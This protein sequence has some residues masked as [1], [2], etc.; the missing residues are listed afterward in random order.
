MISENRIKAIVEQAKNEGVVGDIKSVLQHAMTAGDLIKV[1]QQFHSDTPVEL[2]IPVEIDK[3]T[4]EMFS[5]VGFIIDAFESEGETKDGH[6]I[7]LRACKPEMLQD[8]KDWMDSQE[9]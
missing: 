8:Y 2:E 5:E 9:N 3:K 6:V 4:D 7:T 1:L